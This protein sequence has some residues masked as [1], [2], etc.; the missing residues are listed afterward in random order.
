MKGNAV[1]RAAARVARVNE[2]TNT[3][4]EF[5]DNEKKK[6]PNIINSGLDIDK[7]LQ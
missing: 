4:R 7:S 3:Y 5:P 2:M 1:K 6:F